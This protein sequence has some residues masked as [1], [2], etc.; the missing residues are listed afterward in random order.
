[1]AENFRAAKTKLSSMTIR[2]VWSVT[3]EDMAADPAANSR[4]AE[5]ILGDGLIQN[6]EIM[7]SGPNG[8]GVT[9]RSVLNSQYAF[10]V[11][12][13]TNGK[14]WTLVELWPRSKT[15]IP[16]ALDEVAAMALPEWHSFGFYLWDWIEQPG[17]QIHAIT[18]EVVDGRN[19]VKITFSGRTSHGKQIN[20]GVWL[21][22]PGLDWRLVESRLV[23]PNGGSL[24]FR[25]FRNSGPGFDADSELETKAEFTFDG[26]VSV[27]RTTRVKYEAAEGSLNP[28]DC[29]LTH[30]GLA[31]P[32]QRLI[33]WTSQ[34][35]R[36][37]AGFGIGFVIIGVVVGIYI[38]RKVSR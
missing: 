37:W 16:A 3:D 32:D 25:I 13:A 23:Y 35:Q 8:T 21:C 19:L 29:T 24:R 30:Y 2:A 4:T 7:K 28:G 33:P 10:M 15:A 38:W 12:T 9:L 36:R 20:Q 31:E 26:K 1:V 34:S 14:I 11:S 17:F 22:D 27:G 6:T 5:A 18:P